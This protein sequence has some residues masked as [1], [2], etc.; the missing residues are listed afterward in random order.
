[1]YADELKSPE[2]KGLFEITDE[3]IGKELICV[4]R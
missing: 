2:E 4:M 1:M 3:E